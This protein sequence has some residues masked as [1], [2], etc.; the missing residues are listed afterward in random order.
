MGL[1]ENSPPASLCLPGFEGV[2]QDQEVFWGATV[3]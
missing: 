2:A 3:P 1:A